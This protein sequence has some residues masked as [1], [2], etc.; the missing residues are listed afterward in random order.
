M[1]DSRLEHLEGWGIA[2]HARSRVY[3]PRHPGQAAEA[4]ADARERGLSVVH[5]GGGQSYGDAALNE[6]GATIVTT[7]LD[8][9]L[10]LDEEEGLLRAEAGVT[11]EAV[12][13]E[14]LPRGW[15]PPVVPGTMAVT[16][17]GAVAM[18][19]HGKNH[20]AEG[21]LGDHVEALAV[22]RADGSVDRLLRKREPEAL[23]A[24]IGAQGLNGTIL[25]VTLRMRRVHS[26]YLRVLSRSA[27]DLRR[28]L[29]CLE[30]GAGA[31]DYAVAWIDAFP[32]RRAG[33]GI[34]HFA[35]YLP[36]DH[37]LVGRGLTLQAQHL[38]ARIM[39]VLPRSQAWRVLK[40][41]T[42]DPGMRAVNAG[43]FWAGLT[44]HRRRY[45]QSHARF[46]FLLDYMPGW[47]RVYRPHGFLQN[48]LFVPRVAALS[49]FRTALDL[50]R[51]TG[52]R[53]YLAVIKRHRADDSAAG[54]LLDGYSLALDLPVRPKRL[55]ELR[56][57]CRSYDDL[58]A[59]VGG[60]VYAAKDFVG[61][62]RLPP[63][64]DPLFSSN[65][66]RRWERGGA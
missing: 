31:H 37:R 47:K 17:G 62:G 19:V 29:A 21:A 8:R 65:L 1:I 36:P 14:A 23:R 61:V 63:E 20:F 66:V 6:G 53:S 51:R 18:N 11:F 4:L 44:R 34:V 7:G 28:T 16:L 50:Q 41:F 24:V 12:W 56:R 13:Q 3:R 55:A 43:R 57:L 2:P 39:G 60:H 38:P 64:R 48:Q 33:R 49:A 10:A 32:R 30:E 5:R 27:R 22:L 52:V 58:L 45:A 40:P 46:H 42:N 35:D 59:E 9:I 15:W 25:E 54:Y 26:G